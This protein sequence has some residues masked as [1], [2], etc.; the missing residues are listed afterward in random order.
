VLTAFQ[1]TIMSVVSQ[2]TEPKGFALAGGG[3]LILKGLVDRHTRDLDFFTRDADSVN[4]ICPAVEAAL[5]AA[6]MS[7]E[8]R[9]D[10][11][12]F[13]RLEVS[14][15]HD[16]CEVDLGHDARLQPE[17]PSAL[18]PVLATEE[19]AADKTLALFGRAAARD[20]VDVYSLVQ[21]FG[22]DRLCELA[23][24]KDHGF[25]KH[26]FADA[27]GAF[28]RLDRDLFEVDN[29]TY[30]SIEEWSRSWH[31]RLLQ[32]GIERTARE[33]PVDRGDDTGLSL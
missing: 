2:V 13:I 18:G 9:V 8:R 31:D 32:Q 22:E 33:I 17:E 30:L 29:R 3:A 15:D 10:A 11:P 6:G 27:L 24:Q 16:M 23:V 4:Q 19:L 7:V 1:E 5:R 28:G 21:L 25:D 26:H 20:F 14:R 12:G